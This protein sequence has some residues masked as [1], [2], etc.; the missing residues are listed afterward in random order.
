[1]SIHKLEELS[2]ATLDGL[3]RSRTVVILIVSP[4][5]E[6][7]P[8]LPLGVDAFT[9][10]HFAQTLAQRIIAERTGWQVVLAP[11]LYLGSFTFDHV[12]TVKIRQRVVRDLLV[13]Y[14]S[15]LARAGFRYLLISNGHAGPGHLVALEEAAQKVSRKFGV[16]MASFT[17]HLAWEFLRGKYLEKIEAALGHPLTP[18]ERQ[19]F[20]E[21]A[22]GGWWE[23]SMMLLLRPELVD[24]GYKDLPATRYRLPERLRPNYP[25]RDGRPGYVGHPALGDPAF[26]RA[27]TQVL[28][29]Q[30]ME[31][32]NALLDGRLR[33]SARRSPFFLIPFLRTNFWPAVTGALLVGAGLLAWWVLQRS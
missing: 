28:V 32:A 33:P 12:G 1:M 9:A 4:L 27:S 15:A 6:H 10:Q 29:D 13:D 11:P 24:P 19:A 17:G 25:V 14:G 30:A 2:T 26:A 20:G 5:E 21:D 7:G 23:T 8:H 31:L 16:T 18:V 3:D 22:H